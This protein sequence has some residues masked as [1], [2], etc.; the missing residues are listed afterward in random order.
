MLYKKIYGFSIILMLLSLS[1]F[2]QSQLLV[3]PLDNFEAT[4][5]AYLKLK[6][7]EEIRLK[8]I[9]SLI[10]NVNGIHKMVVKT[11]QNEKMKI[12]VSDVEYLYS[13]PYIKFFR[14]KMSNS[15]L[16]DLND[17]YLERGFA[18]LKSYKKINLN[19]AL[20]EIPNIDDLNKE[21]KTE[22]GEKKYISQVL[23]PTFCNRVYI[24]LDPNNSANAPDIG[25]AAPKTSFT[26][27]QSKLSMPDEIT[28]QLKPQKSYLLYFRGT[29]GAFKLK[30]SSYKAAFSKIW[31]K[32]ESMTEEY[33][34]PKWADLPN[35]ILSY[36]KCLED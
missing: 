7:K 35:H 26:I 20:T 33:K 15:D 2:S 6:D 11:E 24:M 4:K 21:F 30:K 29:S 18:F 13:L 1:S 23:N 34:K 17:E 14:E 5:E 12:S 16:S 22:E 36:T 31:N 27:G 9:L 3:E 32:C 8:R 25:L 28:N 10:S 19:Q